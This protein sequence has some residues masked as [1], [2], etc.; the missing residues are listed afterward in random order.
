MKVIVASAV[1]SMEPITAHICRS[2]RT[3][4]ANTSSR[5]NFSVSRVQRQIPPESPAYID[6]P[7]SLQAALPWSRPV[8][9]TLPVP[10]ELFPASRPD[11]PSELYLQHLTPDALPKNVK[12][13][14]KGQER[15]RLAQLRKEQLRQGLTGLYA[16]KQAEI[17]A[18]NNRSTNKQAERSRLLRQPEREDARLTS[19]S[20]TKEMQP[21]HAHSLDALLAEVAAAKRIHAQKLDNVA[22]HAQKKQ[23][24]RLDHLHTLYMNARSFITNPHQLNVAIAEQFDLSTGGPEA[25]PAHADF[26]T[27]IGSGQSMWQFGPPESIKDMVDDATD[28]PRDRTAKSIRYG[29]NASPADEA[30]YRR[31]QDRFKKIAERLSGGKM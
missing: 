13:S 10:R 12:S 31:E 22:R 26:K 18:M 2:C 6:I 5:R 14:A 24:E 19:T 25:V 30:R 11:K 9:G 3:R 23:E 1:L 17:N 8:K 28:T 29:K 7:S 15:A 4:L 27:D 21:A 16:R 20:V